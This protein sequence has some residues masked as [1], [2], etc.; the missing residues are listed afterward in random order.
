MKFTK[1]SKLKMA[2]TR[3]GLLFV[4]P[5]LIGFGIFYLYPFIAS[6]YYSFTSYSLVGESQWIGVLNYKELFIEDDLFKT[7]LY[8]T[9]Y[10]AALFVPLSLVVGLIIALLLNTNIKGKSGLRAIYFLP[11]IIPLAASG[12]LWVWIL[13]SRYGIINETLRALGLP[14]PRW[15]SDPN[16]SKPGYVIMSVWASGQTM[17]ILLAGLTGVPRQL[18]EV[19]E[20]DGANWLHK[21]V[22]ITLPLLTPAI[23]FILIISVIGS[24]QMFTQA[25]IM[26]DGAPANSTLFYNLYLYRVSFRYFKMGYGCAMAWILFVIVFTL[27]WSLFKS[28]AR[29][30]YYGREEG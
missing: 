21:I 29:W 22:Y 26:T 15:F 16:W 8:N 5:F 17:I 20:L 18:Y 3:N 10:Y 23:L 14:A 12:I 30:V 2:N 1:I 13:N 9:L 6:F 19:A 28:S 4:S 24:F 27:A 25:Y 7:S 11:S